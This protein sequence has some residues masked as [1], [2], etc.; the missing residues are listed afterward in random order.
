MG[1][2]RL[3]EDELTPIQKT[4]SKMTSKT[5]KYRHTHWS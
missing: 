5:V 1:D 2:A 4:P 3:L